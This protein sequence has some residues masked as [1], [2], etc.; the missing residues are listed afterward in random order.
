MVQ[1]WCDQWKVELVVISS[2]DRAG[3]CLLQWQLPEYIQ[4]SIVVL[5]RIVSDSLDIDHY[6]F[7]IILLWI[8]WITG[9]TSMTLIMIY[10]SLVVK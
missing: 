4:T 6:Q 1:C 3:D 7:L 9:Q 2:L 5:K 10:T 8:L